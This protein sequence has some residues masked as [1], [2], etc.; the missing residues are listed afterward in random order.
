MKNWLEKFI[1]GKDVAINLYEVCVSHHCI[2]MIK[3]E[4]FDKFL[5]FFLDFSHLVYCILSPLCK[6]C[7]VCYTQHHPQSK[8]NIRKALSHMFFLHVALTNS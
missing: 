4:N 7:C 2:S 6:R 8:G 3:E 5:T 1:K